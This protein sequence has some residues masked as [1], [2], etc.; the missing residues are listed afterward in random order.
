[1]I[2]HEIADLAGV[3]TN[4][5]RYYSRIGLLRPTRNPENGYRANVRREPLKFALLKCTNASEAQHHIR[6]AGGKIRKSAAVVPPV[7]SWAKAV[8]ETIKTNSPRQRMVFMRFI[9]VFL[10]FYSFA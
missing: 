9:E 7:A 5:V 1:M 8:P 4:V 2:A 3:K 6:V 10:T